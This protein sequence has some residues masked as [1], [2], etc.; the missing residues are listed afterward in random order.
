M[1]YLVDTGVLLRFTNTQDPQH[2]VVK[3]TVEALVSRNEELYMTT[4]NAA[5]FWNVSTRPKSD[6]GL[7]LPHN[8]VTDLLAQTIEPMCTV[9]VERRTLYSELKRLLANYAVVG[10]QVHDARLVAMMLTWQIENVLTLNDRDFRRYEP[11][12]ITIVTP[13]SIAAAGP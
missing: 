13:P 7:G 12:G 6:N 3:Q 8:T 5:E 11:E 1:P 2:P 4:Q 10:K 9:L